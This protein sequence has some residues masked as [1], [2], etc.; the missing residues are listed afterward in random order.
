MSAK[1]FSKTQPVA[2]LVSEVFRLKP[3]E[4]ENPMR[5]R[6]L[7]WDKFDEVIKGIFTISVAQRYPIDDKKNGLRI[8]LK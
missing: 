2:E 5:V 7:N 6:K 1:G 3:G 4:L 8:I